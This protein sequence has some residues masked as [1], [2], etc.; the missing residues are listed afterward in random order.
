MQPSRFELSVNKKV[1][2]E[3][4]ITIPASVLVRADRVIE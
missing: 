2:K 4:G 1:A 3:L